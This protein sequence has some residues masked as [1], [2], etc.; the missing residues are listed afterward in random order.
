MAE[1]KIQIKDPDKLTDLDCNDAASWIAFIVAMFM[2]PV[3]LLF[4]WIQ[5]K[6]PLNEYGCGFL[7]LC[8]I[9][10]LVLLHQ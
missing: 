1:G 7:I 6:E 2:F 9:L 4:R 3:F 10:L 8:G 5:E